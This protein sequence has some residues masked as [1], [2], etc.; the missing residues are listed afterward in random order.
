MLTSFVERE[1]P[2]VKRGS[3]AAMGWIR[4]EF[5]EEKRGKKKTKKIETGAAD[6]VSLLDNSRVTEKRKKTEGDVEGEL[7]NCGVWGFREQEKRRGERGKL[8]LAM[9]FRQVWIGSGLIVR[10]NW[11][12]GMKLQL[13][14]GSKG[15]LQQCLAEK[16]N[17]NRWLKLT[18]QERL[19]CPQ[20]TYQ[21]ISWS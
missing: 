16:Q 11:A 12:D 21:Y 5:G 20:L 7:R 8:K 13:Y 15:K 3:S 6:S 9:F 1:M 14:F 17:L 4:W 18:W 19:D 10:E 2:A